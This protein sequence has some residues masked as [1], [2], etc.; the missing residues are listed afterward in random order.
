MY[1]A[2]PTISKAATPFVACV[3]VVVEVAL[4]A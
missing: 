1:W 3:S 4:F 2:D